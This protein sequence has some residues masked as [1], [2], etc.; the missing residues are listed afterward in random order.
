MN[1]S[2]LSNRPEEISDQEASSSSCWIARLT[3]CEIGSNIHPIVRDGSEQ[4]LA[5]SSEIL[6]PVGVID[7]L[8]NRH[9]RFIHYRKPV[10]SHAADLV[11]TL[12][13]SS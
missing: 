3:P 1:H 13:E 5:I 8:I 4:S 9:V 7:G 2:K 6:G 11:S 10:L 12:T